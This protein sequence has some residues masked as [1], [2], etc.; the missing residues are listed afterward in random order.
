[1]IEINPSPKTTPMAVTKERATTTPTK[2]GKGLPILEV[3]K[4]AAP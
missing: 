4:M 3:I 1:M 2:T